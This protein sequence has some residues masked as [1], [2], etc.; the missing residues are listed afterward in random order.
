MKQTETKK[1]ATVHMYIWVT[2]QQ[3]THAPTLHNI[4]FSPSLQIVLL[5]SNSRTA[6]F[7]VNDLLKAR[8]MVPA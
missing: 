7:A 4:I 3:K 8:H 2:C 5:F 1:Q 6:S